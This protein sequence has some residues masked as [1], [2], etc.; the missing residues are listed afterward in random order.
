MLLPLY[1]A[2]WMAAVSQ[3]SQR[4]PDV[5]RFRLLTVQAVVA[6]V[7]ALIILPTFR[8][9]PFQPATELFTMGFAGL[10]VV[11][12]FAIAVLFIKQFDAV[13]LRWLRPWVLIAW[14]ML[15]SS[16]VIYY[17]QHNH[18]LLMSMLPPWLVTTALLHALAATEKRGVFKAWTVFLA[19]S[20]FCFGAYAVA[21]WQGVSLVVISGCAV[22]VSL[23]L[24]SRN[25]KY[26]ID[27]SG[28]SVTSREMMILLNNAF[29]YVLAV[30]LLVHT[31]GVTFVIVTALLF[32]IGIGPYFKWQHSSLLG[33]TYR[34]M[35]VGSVSLLLAGLLWWWRGFMWQ[36]LSLGGFCLSIWILLHTLNHW[37]SFNGHRF[38][39]KRLER[40]QWAMLLAHCGVAL[41]FLGITFYKP[42]AVV[43]CVLLSVS[44]VCALLDRRYRVKKRHL[45]Y[46]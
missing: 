17:Y 10:S 44:G 7:Y 15:T 35:I 39:I 37:I 33:L 40:S 9:V 2:L 23:L 20:A 8:V 14:V 31:T 25:A 24:L 16:L 34:V 3:F 4:L 28:Y 21:A 30:L 5:L 45:N 26:F 13:W 36:P 32:F 41:I 29:L 27:H 42:M 22:V 11:Y 46:T 18:V 38:T 19:A 6:V 43:G 12:G 1:I